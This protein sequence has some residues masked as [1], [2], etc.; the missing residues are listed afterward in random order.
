MPEA[1]F[2]NEFIN[3]DLNAIDDRR[4]REYALVGYSTIA[5]WGVN[6]YLVRIFLALDQYQK[7]RSIVGNLFE[8]GVF[9]G[10]VLILL[11]LAAR[12][13]E[14]VVALDLF[15]TFQSHNIDRSGIADSE[16]FTR[17]IV[18]QNLVRYGLQEKA[19]LI[20]GDS[21]F[22]DFSKHPTLSNVRFAHID[23]AHYVDAL[24]NDL[25]KTQQIMASGGIIVVDD[26]NHPGFPGVNEGCHRFLSLATPRLVIPFAVGMNKL[27]LTTHS[28][29]AHLIKYMHEILIKPYGK[30]VKLHG[31]DTVCVDREY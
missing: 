8:L 11:G 25:V 3:F 21:L 23:G 13:N 14:R 7:S 1:N 18:E 4:L 5:G 22:I 26:Y 6:D 24:V 16:H 31:F 27:F 20:V 19:D 28:Y 30:L 17:E 15:E 12:D 29:H 10:R 9:H 2:M